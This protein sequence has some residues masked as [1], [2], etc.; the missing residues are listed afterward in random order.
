MDT[1]SDMETVL[2][3]ITLKQQPPHFPSSLKTIFHTILSYYH[4]NVHKLV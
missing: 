4:D 2:Q 1:D 3:T